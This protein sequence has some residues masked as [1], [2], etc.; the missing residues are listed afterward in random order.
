LLS[1]VVVMAVVPMASSGIR[2]IGGEDDRGGNRS[3]SENA[4]PQGT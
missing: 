1:G 4:N 3:Q 2:G